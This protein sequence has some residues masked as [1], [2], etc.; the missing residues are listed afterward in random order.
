MGDL[1]RPPDL[2]TFLG[3]PGSY[4]HSPPGV[5]LVQTHASYVAIA[6][7]FVYKVKK[8]LDLGFLDFST[9]EKRR[10]FCELEVQLNRR[11]CADIYEGVIPISLRNGALVLGE[12]EEIVDYA[13]KM[14]R[15][16]DG[17]FLH[18]RLARGELG[19]TDLERIADR[20]QK[21]YRA[22]ASSPEVA[23]W[24][25]IERLKVSTDENFRQTEALLGSSLS[26]PAWEAIR[27]YTDRFYQQN[28]R[29][30]NRRR[31]EGHVLDCHGDLHLEHVHLTPARVCIYDCI[32]FN[33][34][35][36]CIDVASDIAFLA[37]DLERHGRHD[38][39]GYLVHRMAEALDDPELLQLIDFY[40]CYRAFVRGKVECIRAA[41]PE[42]PVAQQAASREQ[43]QRYFQLALQYALAGGAPLVLIVMGRVGTG[44]STQARALADALGWEALSS[45]RIRKESF[46]LP[47]YERAEEAMRARLYAEEASERTY[48]ALQRSAVESARR[49]AGTV[50]DATFSRRAYRDALRAV[51]R[52][53]RLRYCFIELECATDVVAERLRRREEGEP[54]I[55]DARLPEVGMLNAR[56]EAPDALEETYHF[57][58]DSS[59]PAEETTTEI[60]QHL[61]R[62]DLADLATPWPERSSLERRSTG[63]R[64]DPPP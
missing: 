27:Y 18:Q 49:G 44:K 57:T 3:D 64:P 42:V 13:V 35:L 12:G 54:Q 46:G 45:D 6:P 4:P 62:F 5:E 29:L 36:R 15:L 53:N 31:A 30:L 14:Q 1:P 20:L 39:A 23:A 47:L 32:E 28:T 63:A 11:L 58:A 41:E 10:H 16:S 26:R 24:G 59:L 51:L 25:R 38:L 37:M 17:D 55:S 40:K 22:Q 33:E 19:R 52:E 9:L 61:I 34:R 48:A 60:L 8:P 56:Y 50:L 7:P 2:L 21:F 43:A